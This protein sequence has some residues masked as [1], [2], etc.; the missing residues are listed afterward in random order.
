[1]DSLYVEPQKR[2]DL[3]MKKKGYTQNK[4]WKTVVYVGADHKESE[5]QKQ[6]V[7]ALNFLLPETKKSKK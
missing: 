7:D 3:L 1:L 5:W 4:N 6:M 2:I